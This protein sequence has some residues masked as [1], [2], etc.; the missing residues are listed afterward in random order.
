MVEYSR[1]NEQAIQTKSLGKVTYIATRPWYIVLNFHFDEHLGKSKPN[2]VKFYELRMEMADI[3]FGMLFRQQTDFVFV[4]SASKLM[5]LP[6][7]RNNIREIKD[8]L[9]FS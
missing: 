5:S 1:Q 7:T 3:T 8:K 2:F 6:E 4:I 9:P